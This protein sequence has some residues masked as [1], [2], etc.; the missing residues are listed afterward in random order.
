[1]NLLVDVGLPIL[2]QYVKRANSG[3]LG[4]PL[5]QSLARRIDID[6]LISDLK[7]PHHNY[8]DVEYKTV[9]SLDQRVNEIIKLANAAALDPTVHARAIKITKGCFD[10]TV[11]QLRKIDSY[12]RKNFDYTQEAGE[13]LQDPRLMLDGTIE[14]GDCDDFSSL[15]GAL[16]LSLRVPVKFRVSGPDADTATHIFPLVS[17]DKDN[18]NAPY[19]AMDLTRKE[20]LGYDLTDKGLQVVVKDYEL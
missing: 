16:A 17:T 20:P 13:I 15:V 8:I 14:G 2:L 1:M 19:V 10:N 7:A 5:A 18:P 11:C 9:T 6:G 3:P 4:S 12:L